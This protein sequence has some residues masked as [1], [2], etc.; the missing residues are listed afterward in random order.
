MVPVNV[1]DGEGDVLAQTGQRTVWL[2]A[3]PG[4]VV[5]RAGVSISGVQ[6]SPET[7]ETSVDLRPGEV[8]LLVLATP[9]RSFSGRFDKPVWC[10]PTLVRQLG[11]T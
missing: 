8:A 5:I 3:E 1:L 6:L 9:R 4:R 7:H 11:S 10:A 2:P